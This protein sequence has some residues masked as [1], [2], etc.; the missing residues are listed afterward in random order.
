MS[1]SASEL[2]RP[3]AVSVGVSDDTLTVTL[4]DGRTISAPLDWYPRLKEATPRERDHWELVGHGVGVHWPDLDEDI[5][6]GALLQGRRSH[7]TQ[8]SLKKW[9][10]NRTGR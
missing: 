6:V 7:E 1:S 5:S 9:L 3:L 4:S 10:A 8:A 2:S